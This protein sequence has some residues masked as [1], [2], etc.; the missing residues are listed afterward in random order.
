MASFLRFDSVT[1]TDT[2][3][4]ELVFIFEHEYVCFICGVIAANVY[5]Y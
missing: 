4:F 1:Q 2:T 3:F 5:A